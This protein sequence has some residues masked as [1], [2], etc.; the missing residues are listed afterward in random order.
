MLSRE[1]VIHRSAGEERNARRRVDN[2]TGSAADSR[3]TRWVW[4]KVVLVVLIVGLLAAF[5]LLNQGSVV[6]PRVHLVFASYARPSLLVVMLLTAVFSAA[7]AL[8]VRAAFGAARQLREVR[9]RAATARLK[10]PP[11][12]VKE[13]ALAAGT[14]S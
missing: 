6:E 7:A 8:L 12:L 9:A 5:L 3:L 11:N 2:Q 10:R 1:H 4:T 14:A 13:P